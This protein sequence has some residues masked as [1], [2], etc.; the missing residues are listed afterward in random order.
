MCARKRLTIAFR[1]SMRGHRP[2]CF[3]NQWKKAQYTLPSTTIYL[4]M[5]QS[6][7]RIYHSYLLFRARRSRSSVKRHA[8][9]LL[10]IVYIMSFSWKPAALRYPSYSSTSCAFTNIL[11][12]MGAR[13]M[14][15]GIAKASTNGPATLR[16]SEQSF[17]S[18]FW[19]ALLLLGA[20]TSWFRNTK[21][22][23]MICTPPYHVLRPAKT[24]SGA[25]ELLP[26]C[27]IQ[28]IDTH[29][30]C[31][32]VRHQLQCGLAAGVP[33][34]A[35][36]SHEAVIHHPLYVRVGQSQ[37][38]RQALVPGIKGPKPPR[39][40]L[41]PR[42]HSL[43]QPARPVPAPRPTTSYSPLRNRGKSGS[44][45]G[46]RHVHCKTPKKYLHSCVKRS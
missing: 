21:S 34:S 15:S 13:R 35:H 27:M 2:Q 44:G 25:T 45:N 43:Q 12:P 22:L 16:R 28:A 29:L 9:D 17:N 11:V 31:K 20:I 41:Q 42:C 26:F 1:H 5:P 8:N 18:S 37:Q 4:T 3:P 39:V 14:P 32:D 6:S 38:V 30:K 19:I 23:S 24:L 7:H 46:C 40:L 33:A 36:S 10:C